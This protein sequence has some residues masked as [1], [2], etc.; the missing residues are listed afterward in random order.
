MSDEQQYDPEL[1][2]EETQEE[3][4]EDDGSI[5]LYD[6]NQGRTPRTGGPYVD[7]IERRQAEILRAQVEGR[8]P[9]L[10]NPPPTVGTQLVTQDKLVDTDVDKEFYDRGP[11][12][13]EPVSSFTPPEE[14]TEP[15]PR[16]ADWDND[17]Q[18]VAA[19]EASA[20]LEAAKNKS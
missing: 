7:E 5:K 12:T 16:Q 11:V 10:D 17:T 20:R 13:N 6:A 14:V 4:Q 2:L 9:D 1:E 19:L 8:E 3:T 18:K 15:D